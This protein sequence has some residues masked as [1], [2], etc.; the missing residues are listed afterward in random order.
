MPTRYG[1]ESIS[2]DCLRPVIGRRQI[3]SRCSFLVCP[4]P[5]VNTY[6]AFA[7]DSL[8][9]NMWSAGCSVFFFFVI[10][11]TLRLQRGE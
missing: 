8:L 2:N 6:F 5:W 4:R 11:A 9:Q 10:A 1:E 3:T 7:A